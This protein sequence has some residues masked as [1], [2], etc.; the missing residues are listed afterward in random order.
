MKKTLMTALIMTLPVVASASRYNNQINFGKVIQVD[1]IYQNVTIPED[2][3]VCDNR[4]VNHKQRSNHTGKTILGGII[5][6]A[7]GNKFGRGH[8]RDASTA[9]GVLIGASIGANKADHH[10][11]QSRTCYIETIYHNEEQ[12]VGY[13]VTYEYNGELYQT[14][15]QNHPGDRVKLRVNIDV[16]D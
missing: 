10:R 12:M 6:G 4:R 11:S 5:G 15:M 9:L 16:V 14:Q 13:D 7:I 3:K 2:R 8:G 1:P